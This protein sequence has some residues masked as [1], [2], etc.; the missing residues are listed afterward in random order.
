MEEAESSGCMGTQRIPLA[1][2]LVFRKQGF[3]ESYWARQGDEVMEIF[4][5]S[6]KF[7]RGGVKREDG[8]GLRWW[9]CSSTRKG[10]MLTSNQGQ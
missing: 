4:N 6:H 8:I 2:Q 1:D 3:E 5:D 10:L 9:A 7:A